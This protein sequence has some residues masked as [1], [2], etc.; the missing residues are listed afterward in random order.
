[1]SSQSSALVRPKMVKI[2][3]QDKTLG[4]NGEDV[5]RF[6]ESFEMAAEVDGA[7]EYDM[8][9]QLRFF[10]RSSE[11][12]NIVESMEGYSTRDWPL[13]RKGLLA[14]WGKIDTAR[15]TVHDIELLVTGWSSKGGVSSVADFQSFRKSWDPIQSYLITN[16]HIDTAEEIRTHY[17]QAFSS[18]VQERIRDK[19]VTN[20]TMILTRDN[21]FKLPSFQILRSTIEDVMKGQTALT[22]EESTVSAAIPSVSFQD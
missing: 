6:L 8:A 11:V 18:S 3:P 22:F 20:K 14:Y 19:L 16:D 13:L 12:L 1:M 9:Y 7:S 15:F 5:E 21:R 4:F 10:I 17:Y 2:K